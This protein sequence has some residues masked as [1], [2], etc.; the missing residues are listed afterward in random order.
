MP[1][2]ATIRVNGHGC[3]G[4]APQQFVLPAVPAQSGIEI[5]DVLPGQS[6][7]CSTPPNMSVNG[8][9]LFT[10]SGL[11]TIS[12]PVCTGYTFS[13]TDCCR[14]GAAVN[15][16]N[17]A[18]WSNIYLEA[19]VFNGISGVTNSSPVL[20]ASPIPYAC[21]LDTLAYL[22]QA[23]D[24]DGDSLAFSLVG[25]S[26]DSSTIIPNSTLCSTSH[27]F[28]IQ[29]Y[30][31]YDPA[32]GLLRAHLGSWLGIY[33]IVQQIDEYRNINGTMVKVGSMWHDALFNVTNC[34]SPI[35]RLSG[36][37]QLQQNGSTTL[38]PADAVI[39]VQAGQP[40][41]L[42]LSAETTDPNRVLALT[43]NHQLEVPG[44]QLSVTVSG[45]T[46]TGTFSWTPS[47]L[48]ISATPYFFSYRFQ[49][50][51]T[52]IP[53][54][55]YGVIKLRVQGVTAVAEAAETAAIPNVL[56]PQAPFSAVFT[57]PNAAAGEYA[58]AVYDRLG[59]TVYQSRRYANDWSGANVSGGL[60][61]YRLQHL[62]TGEVRNGKLTVL[63]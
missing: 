53:N 39:P 19:Y 61:L 59:R 28:G 37:V 2:T 3:S 58:L 14:N 9:L 40:L 30:H 56:S 52:P 49:D 22:P 18:A 21:I 63:K 57:V 4:F 60:Y 12:N 48:Q 13:F 42:V 10:Y 6:T 35:P 54:D 8:F 27:P 62:K 38:Y 33:A 1:A 5:S 11:V 26:S 15:L 51:A 47:S 43:S 34:T 32:T 24:P 44:S 31:S 29:F 17:A 25:T 16:H 20:S 23:T 55:I 7:S 41:T 36:S 45:Q 50:D 46:T